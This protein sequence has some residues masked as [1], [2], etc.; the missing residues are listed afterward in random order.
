MLQIAY[1]LEHVG[2]F[3]VDYNFC[4]FFLER[5]FRAAR[6]YGST[7]PFKLFVHSLV[8]LLSLLIHLLLF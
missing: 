8:E 7:F 1:I 4:F 3:F 6:H 2:R 5:F